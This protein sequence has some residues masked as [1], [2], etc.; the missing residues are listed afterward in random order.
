MTPNRK[1]I[2][3]VRT[4]HGIITVFFLSCIIYIYYSGIT[5]QKT[6]LAYIAVAFIFIEGLVVTLNKGICPLGPLH[7]MFGDQKTF[8]ELFLP[9]PVAKKAVPFLGAV[10]FIGFLLLIF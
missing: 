5:N 1:M 8:F 3:L 7:K 10:A 4:L 2:Y 9:K 6:T